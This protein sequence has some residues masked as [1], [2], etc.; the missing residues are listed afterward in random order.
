MILSIQLHTHTEMSNKSTLTRTELLL[1]EHKQRNRILRLAE[2]CAQHSLGNHHVKLVPRTGTGTNGDDSD[3]FY[4]MSSTIVET[5]LLDIQTLT[6][7]VQQLQQ[8]TILAQQRIHSLET[9][10]HIQ[11]TA[12]N[13]FMHHHTICHQNEPF[14]TTDPVIASASNTLMTLASSQ[15]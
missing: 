11:H 7:T 2:F 12:V 13:A 6:L 14:T 5:L 8:H 4:C 3:V 9:L 1:N 15:K 10:S